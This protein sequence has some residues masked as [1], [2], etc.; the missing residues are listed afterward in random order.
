MSLGFG[1]HCELRQSLSHEQRLSHRHTQTLRHE[2]SFKQRERHARFPEAICGVEG[3]LVAHKYL[4]ERNLCG[5]LV[6]GL[7]REC[8][9]NHTEKALSEHKDVDVIVL[10]KNF[11]PAKKFECGIDWWVAN[12]K[13]VVSVSSADAARSITPTTYFQNGNGIALRYTVAKDSYL[14]GPGLCI[15]TIDSLLNIALCEVESKSGL[16]YERTP[17]VLK[18]VRRELPPLRPQTDFF[19]MKPMKDPT[20]K[21]ISKEVYSGISAGKVY[22]SLD[23]VPRL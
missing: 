8:Y 1:F 12:H 4:M 13:Y 22:D 9:D 19:G 23:D 16:S 17:S 14:S 18:K 10:D 21:S 3:I 15:P 20:F 6:G 11:R 7:A 2:L 5:V